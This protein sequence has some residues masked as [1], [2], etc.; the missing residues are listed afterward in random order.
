MK[1]TSPT[2]S[3]SAP[4]WMSCPTGMQTA[5]HNHHHHQVVR[6]VEGHYRVNS[7]P[8][9]LD[10]VMHMATIVATVLLAFC[11]SFLPT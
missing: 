6:P 4:Y 8:L 11:V 3:L 10:K 7:A 9:V 5:L 2:P 1:V